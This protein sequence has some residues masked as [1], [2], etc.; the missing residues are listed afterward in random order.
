ML[1]TGHFWAR[2]SLP[3]PFGPCTLKLGFEVLNDNF[4]LDLDI[5]GVGHLNQHVRIPRVHWN[6]VEFCVEFVPCRPELFLCHDGHT[7]LISMLAPN[8]VPIDIR[9]VPRI[10]L[11]INSPHHILLGHLL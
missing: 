3:N 7:R 10:D 11:A 4:V 8:C 1:G 9:L 2:S 6:H 5:E